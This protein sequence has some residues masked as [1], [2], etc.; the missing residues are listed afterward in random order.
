MELSIKT[1]HESKIV[2]KSGIN[3]Q[4]GTVDSLAFV[5]ILFYVTGKAVLSAVYVNSYSFMPI[6]K[7]V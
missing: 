4:K 6:V 1:T 7:H 5:F 2:F 3:K